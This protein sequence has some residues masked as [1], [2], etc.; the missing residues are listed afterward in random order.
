LPE[1]QPASRNGNPDCHNPSYHISSCNIPGCHGPSC[2]SPR[3]PFHR[4]LH[5]APVRLQPGRRSSISLCV[6][7]ESSLSQ[8][9]PL[10][11]QGS[12]GTSLH[13]YYNA[14]STQ[15]FCSD[16]TPVQSILATGH[17]DACGRNWDTRMRTSSF[18]QA[19]A[20]CYAISS[21]GVTAVVT[22][23]NTCL[24]RCASYQRAVF[25]ANPGVGPLPCIY[26]FV[27]D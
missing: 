9:I 17:R 11:Q 26:Y 20:V 13:S 15:C 2:H 27:Y 19:D 23:V 21:A 25:R 22:G 7:C 5:L 10:I 24:T 4:L 6:P 18:R 8:R 1:I 14:T 12:C 3:K 16:N